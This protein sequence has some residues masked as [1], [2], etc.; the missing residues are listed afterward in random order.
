MKEFQISLQSL[1]ERDDLECLNLKS[2]EV[3]KR[4]AKLLIEEGRVVPIL[5][6]NEIDLKC[7]K[8]NAVSPRKTSFTKLSTFKL[9][10]IK[11]LD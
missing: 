3:L 7:Y 1:F 4:M 9:D 8:E 11:G 6:N 5:S 10:D 2:L